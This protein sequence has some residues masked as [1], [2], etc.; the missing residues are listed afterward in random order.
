M[1]LESKAEEICRKKYPF[2]RLVISKTE[3][4]ELFSANPFKVN[5]HIFM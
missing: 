3:A 4:L 2:Q 1:K 5:R